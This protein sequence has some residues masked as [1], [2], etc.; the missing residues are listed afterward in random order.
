MP[1]AD[2]LTKWN[3]HE[4]INNTKMLTMNPSERKLNGCAFCMVFTWT[5]QAKM[6]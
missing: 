3:E 5:C 4:I 2:E 6:K 1:W